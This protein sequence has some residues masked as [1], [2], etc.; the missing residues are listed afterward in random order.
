MSQIEVGILQYYWAGILN[1]RLCATNGG[2]IQTRQ[3]YI[4]A[5]IY[6]D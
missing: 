1:D 3:L 4:D 5:A 6:I 2:V